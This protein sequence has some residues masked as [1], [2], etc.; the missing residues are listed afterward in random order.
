MPVSDESRSAAEIIRLIHLKK[1]AFWE[2]EREACAL[3]LFHEAARRVP[4]YKDFLRKQ[5][6]NPAKIKTFS[7]FQ[8]VPPIS[9]KDYLRQYPLEKLAWNGSLKRPL[10]WTS[11]SGST[12]EPFYFPRSYAIDQ[13]TSLIHE[14]F[15]R[16]NSQSFNSPTLVLV[17]FGMGVWIGGLITYQSF[18]IMREN[19]YP[20]SILTPGINKQEIMNALRKLSPYFKQTILVGYAPF[21]KDIIDEAPHN[22]IN[23]RNLNLRLI[24][25]AEAFTEKFRDYL[26]KK[27]DIKNGLLDTMNIYG[28]ADIGAM[29]WET[30]V[31]ILIRQ[32]AMGR[33]RLFADI[34]HQI[35]R[36]PTLAQYNPFFVTFQ[37]H[38]GELYLTGDN[39]VPLI[40]YGI[41]DHG[42]VFNFGEI[43]EKIKN[44]GL[45]LSR[46]ARER[47]IK[48]CIYEL[49][50]VY[51]YERVD[52]STTLYGLQIY[53][54]TIRE[55]L[56]ES[57]MNKYVTGKL[58]L[59]TRYDR[60]QNQYLEINLEL[61]KRRKTPKKIEKVLLSQIVANLRLK[62]SEYRELYNFLKA[63]AEPRIVFWPAEH[64]L[65]FKLGIKQKWVKKEKA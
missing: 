65:H 12:G 54:E 15:L 17:C 25:A 23:I 19:G 26:V 10:V 43:K 13:Q 7:D 32:L 11:T 3:R 64:P 21:L 31:S 53:P 51:V 30:P 40:R 33:W 55:V 58:T 6:I 62:N 35:Q 42:G 59:I 20:V 46:I 49:P 41:G 24:F 52:L 45:N 63:R 34:F 47:G 18:E 60:R 29:A 56:I 27:A 44:H 48:D 38:A 8:A 1:S 36:T 22:G 28:S 16:N 39:T 37:E 57:P 4:A 61:R 9:K 5:R 14:L 2:R 50:F